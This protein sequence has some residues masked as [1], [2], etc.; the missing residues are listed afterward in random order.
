MVTYIQLALMLGW[1]DVR[2][3]YRRSP[4][5][6]FWVTITT[7]ILISTMGFVFGILFKIPIKEYLPYLTLGILTWNFT[8]GVI[9]EASNIFVSAADLVKQIK[10]PTY[11]YVV[12]LIWKSFIVFL[13]NIALV[14]I[15]F[16]LFGISV[17]WTMF[18]SIIGLAL[19]LLNLGWIVV[20]L[21]IVATRYRD[22]S[23][24]TTSLLT[25]FFYMTPIMWKKDG[26]DATIGENLVRYNPFSIF[27]SLF[28]EP[29]LGIVPDLR[30]WMSAIIM[31]LVGWGLAFL[32][33][34]KYS[35]RVVYWL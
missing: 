35:N 7:G 16:I 4:I 23:Q 2:Q 25:V 31:A 18:L 13:H 21:G 33:S 3:T 12:R 11:V 17:S 8:S 29:L 10:L 28:R 5:G 15:M 26:L 14:P 24:L 9:G 6:P 30:T 34:R 27:I 1:Q 32:I 22:F 19:V 20:S